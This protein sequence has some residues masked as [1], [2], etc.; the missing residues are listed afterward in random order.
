MSYYDPQGTRR[1]H[2][3]KYTR[4]GQVIQA[5]LV[6]TPRTIENPLIPMYRQF[7]LNNPQY[8]IGVVTPSIKTYPYTIDGISFSQVG[9]PTLIPTFSSF[10]LST[11]FSNA[12]ATIVTR[13]PV[14]KSFLFTY[15]PTSTGFFFG[16]QGFLVDTA[17]TPI[18]ISPPSS[19]FLTYPCTAHS[20]LVSR[21]TST[22]SSFMCGFHFPG[23]KPSET[24]G[25]SQFVITV[26]NDPNLDTWIYIPN[27]VYVIQ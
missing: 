19:D 11:S 5:K 13:A 6:N 7:F 1:S 26:T 4:K 16:C 18:Y 20:T 21:T 15:I 2:Q 23:D 12:I 8:G 27:S 24:V 3:R 22:N 10:S 17:S 9:Q 25:T 14:S